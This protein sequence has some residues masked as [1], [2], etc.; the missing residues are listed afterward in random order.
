MV[1]TSCENHNNAYLV[2][3]GW[4]IPKSWCENNG[5]NN[6]F[7]G[8]RCACKTSLQFSSAQGVMLGIRVG[9]YLEQHKLLV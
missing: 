8:K 1:M 5:T 6:I 2:T 9:S 3:T 7:A 4:I